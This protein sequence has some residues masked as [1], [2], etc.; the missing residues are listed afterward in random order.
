[1]SVGREVDDLPHLGRAREGILGRGIDIV[2]TER[3]AA[4]A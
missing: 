3:V 4:L 1:M 2:P